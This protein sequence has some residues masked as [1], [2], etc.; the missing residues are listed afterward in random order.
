MY[1]TENI[2]PSWQ[3]QSFGAMKNEDLFSMQQDIQHAQISGP[4]PFECKALYYSHLVAIHENIKPLSLIISSTSR[5][6]IKIQFW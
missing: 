6:S 2:N 3:Q 5:W 4:I 1:C